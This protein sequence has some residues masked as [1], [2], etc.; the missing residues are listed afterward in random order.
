MIMAEQ[1]RRRLMTMVS[2][3]GY[4]VLHA[5]KISP[6]GSI[7]EYLSVVGYRFNTINVSGIEING[8]SLPVSK[9]IK[10]TLDEGNVVKVRYR[11]LRTCSCMFERTSVQIDETGNIRTGNGLK[12]IDVS[13]LDTSKV[14]TMNNMFMHS[15]AQ[16]VMG[17]AQLDYTN[18]MDM[19][20]MF[21]QMS[22][23]FSIVDF[24]DADLSSV[25]TMENMFGLNSGL[26]EVI[27]AGKVNPDAVVTDMFK[28]ITTSGTFY[29]NPAYDYSHIIAQLPSTWTAVPIS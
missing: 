1:F 3:G 26:S 15:N 20:G 21:W 14:T 13:F 9:A 27:M 25:V 24:G 11:N 5:D 22:S 19:S 7:Y 16:T 8:T 18:V 12:A 28:D 17:L 10:L 6:F 23:N 2:D 4:A 29:Y